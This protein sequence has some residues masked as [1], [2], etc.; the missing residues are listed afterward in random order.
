M[1]LVTQRLSVLIGTYAEIM[2]VSGDFTHQQ[3]VITDHNNARMFWSGSAWLWLPRYQLVHSV[4]TGIAAPTDLVDNALTTYTL[5]KLGTKDQARVTGSV[6]IATYT[7][8]TT[9]AVKL[10]T[11]GSMASGYSVALNSVGQFHFFTEM[12]NADSAASQNWMSNNRSVIGLLS[13]DTVTTT[14]DTGVAGKLLQ[15]NVLKGTAADSIILRKLSVEI[16][17]GGVA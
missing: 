1:A 2:A 4:R 13:G 11:V 9:F 10:G 3:A 7:T 8:D 14:K 5:P 15:V 16:C 17:G 12:T 6:R